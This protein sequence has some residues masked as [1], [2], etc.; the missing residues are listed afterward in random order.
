MWEIRFRL[1]VMSFRL[2]PSLWGQLGKGHFR[3]LK[4]ACGGSLDSG[5][6]LDC[7]LLE[8]GAKDS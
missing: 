6:S 2:P 7:S 1:V 3:I 8:I 4:T 5:Q